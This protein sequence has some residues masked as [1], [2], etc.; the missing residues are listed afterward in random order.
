[1]FPAI[2]LRRTRQSDWSRR[3]VSERAL[4][5]NDLVW[6]IVVSDRADPVEPVAAMPGVE[7]LSLA[8]LAKAAKEAQSLGIPA[9]ALFPHIDPSKKDD[10]GSEAINPDGLI[11]QAIKT[12]KD[13]A[14]DVGVI[15]DVALDPF[16]THGH[17]GLLDDDYVANDGTVERLIE[18]ALIQAEAGCDVVAPSDMMDGRI[19]AIR[20]ALEADGHHNTMILSYAAKYASGFYGP[21]REAIGSAAALKGDKKTYQ[22]DPAN[23]LEAL[24]EVELDIEEGADMVMVKPGLPYLDIVSL[25]AENYDIPVFAFQVSGEYAMIEAAAANGWI[26]GDRVMLESLMSF[27]RAGASGIITYFAKRAAR[28]LNA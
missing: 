6:S 12:I 27:K 18:Q 24:R 19:G 7:R 13:A 14:P 23:R 20:E 11:P 5:V 3:L 16:T 21:Y 9:I 10:Q 8:A 1:M 26:D 4:G 2:R 15:C 22:M 28:L 17:D 25:L